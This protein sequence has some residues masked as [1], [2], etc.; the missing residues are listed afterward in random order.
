MEG[1]STKIAVVLV[2]HGAPP[3][4]GAED[5][6]TTERATA[7]CAACELTAKSLYVLPHGDHLLGYTLR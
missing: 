6:A 4:P 1:R 7:L 3:P 2:Q 5:V